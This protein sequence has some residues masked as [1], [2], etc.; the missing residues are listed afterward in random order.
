MRPEQRRLE[1]TV[2]DETTRTIEG[3]IEGFRDAATLEPGACRGSA[4]GVR[5]PIRLNPPGRGLLAR[6]DVD[7][8]AEGVRPKKR[9]SRSIEHF[10]PLHRVEGDRHIT[11]VMTRLRVVQALAVD[12]HQ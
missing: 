5:S 8:A 1:V 3:R 6:D 9:G 4:A 11:V 10:D 2:V 12:E 7:R